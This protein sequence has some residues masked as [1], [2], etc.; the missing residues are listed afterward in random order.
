MSKEKEPVESKNEVSTIIEDTT[1]VEN[2]DDMLGSAE[3]FKPTASS[4][5]EGRDSNT[6]NLY[7]LDFVASCWY[8]R[9]TG[10]F[11]FVEASP[12]G[13][14]LVLVASNTP[15]LINLETD[16][17]NLA[18]TTW[19]R[20]AVKTCKQ[21]LRDCVASLYIS[22]I[23]GTGFIQ[24]SLLVTR[25]DTRGDE[26]VY[27]FSGV[28]CGRLNVSTPASCSTTPCSKDPCKD[29]CKDPNNHSGFFEQPHK[30]GRSG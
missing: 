7:T 12:A 28:L 18:L 10:Q 25:P 8:D 21:I 30:P 23:P 24:T 4:K 14:P 17:Q 29:P 2:S 19:R 6:L 15:V 9:P 20:V 11:R 27:S 16:P 5:A 22:D 1:L 3:C 26:I 13:R